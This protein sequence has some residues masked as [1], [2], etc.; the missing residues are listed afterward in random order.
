MSDF[1]DKIIKCIEM[2]SIAF[3]KIG[4]NAFSFVKNNYDYEQI[5]KQYAKIFLSEYNLF[6]DI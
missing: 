2:D 3:N 6:Y 1:R 5:A 4:L